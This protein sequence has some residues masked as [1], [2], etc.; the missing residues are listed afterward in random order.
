MLQRYI[1]E[2][3]KRF[4][5]LLEHEADKLKSISSKVSHAIQRGGIIQLFGCGHSHM[6]GEEVFYRAGGLVPIKPIFEE[7]LMLHQGAIRS[8][9]LERQHDYAQTFLENQDIREEDVVFV[10]STS[11]K[12]PVPIDVA[13]YAKEKGAYV[14][15]ICSFDYPKTEQAKHTSG[16]FLQQVVDEAIH[17]YSVIGDAVLTHPK[18]K[19]PFAPTSTVI[20]TT[21][22]NGI[23]AEAIEMMAED[24]F[25]PPIFLSGNVQ[26]ADE[27]N[28][29][30]IDN[31]SSRIPLL[32]QGIE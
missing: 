19:V 14:V 13:L 21:I 3:E 18:V 10:V 31:Y 7:S 20:G 2:I 25:T 22:I 30:L 27:H 5:F 17:N 9:Q 23:I 8:S 11:G 12:N 4:H 6:I 28:R 16:L 32:L 1:Q 26:G 24:G 15:A 29:S